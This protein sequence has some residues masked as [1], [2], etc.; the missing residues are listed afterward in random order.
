MCLGEDRSTGRLGQPRAVRLGGMANGGP[1]GMQAVV[2]CDAPVTEGLWQA[3]FGRALEA[4]FRQAVLPGCVGPSPAGAAA[5]G[6]GPLHW[7]LGLQIRQ[8]FSR[9]VF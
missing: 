1:Q 7:E 8:P 4:S 9:P 5:Q 2:T 3:M 6:A